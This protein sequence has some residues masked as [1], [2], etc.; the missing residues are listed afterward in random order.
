MRIL[1][2]KLI[3]GSVEIID[4]PSPHLGKGFVRVQTLFSAISPGTEGGKIIAGKQSLLAKAKSK[5]KQTKQVIGMCKSL[6]FKATYLKVK[7]KLDG[8]R[9]LG[10][11]LSGIVLEV[12]DGIDHLKKGDLVA[13]AG[14]GYAN[15][16]DEVVVPV[17]LVVKVPTG[18]T[19]EQAA[20]TT[21]G[22]ISM[23]GVR[24]ANP[25]LGDCAVVIGLGVVGQF[26]G[27]LCKA[28]GC[29]TIGID[30]SKSA[31]DLAIESMSVDKAITIPEDNAENI[32]NDFS[33]GRGADLVFVCAGT[34]SKDPFNLATVLVRKKGKVVVLGRVGMEM[35]WVEVYTKELSVDIS[36]SYGPGRYDPNYEEKG[37]DYPYEFVRW[38]E[39][40]NMEAFLD[41]IASGSIDPLSVLTHKI[42]FTEARKAYEIIS[43][44]SEPFCGMLLEYDS[45]YKPTH[46]INFTNDFVKK[47]KDRFGVSFYGCGSFAQTF[48]LPPMKSNSNVELR[49]IC[50]GTGLTAAD[51]GKRYGFRNAVDSIEQI[52]ADSETDA[53]VIATRHDLHGKAVIKALK[54]GKHVFVEKPLCVFPEE[55]E[56]IEKITEELVKKGKMPILQV[57]YNRRFSGAAT[58]GKK[59][60]G[61]KSAPLTMMYRANAGTMPKEHWMQDKEIGGGRLIGEAC[62][63]LDLMQYF[64]DSVPIKISTHCIELDYNSIL[65]TDNS[66]TS[67]TFKDGS[68]GSLGYFSEGPKSLPKER[69]EVLGNARA[70]VINNFQELECF[71]KKKSKKRFSGKGHDQE[72]IAFVKA[73][74]TGELPIDLESTFATTRAILEMMGTDVEKRS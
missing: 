12:G 10:Y 4:A 49:M 44:K 69:F 55:L 21:I 15:H 1:G 71:G 31:S 26:A 56:E 42:S 9:P 7:S 34:S 38:T 13:C 2:Q 70:I 29:R 22:A 68:V 37:L 57:G 46:K 66:V 50:T 51:I 43:E 18:I 40:R 17:N 14:G 64:C 32:I 19:P 35:D 33:R 36:C 16:S 27:Q 61:K 54:A 41:L 65:P 67:I 62:H 5:P 58:H 3:D 20:F 8:A 72:I 74:R 23:Q 28:A 39:G 11:S 73:M 45:N 24:L 48:L 47:E 53:V 60:M 6:G 52:V 59:F 30:I 63:F 25:A